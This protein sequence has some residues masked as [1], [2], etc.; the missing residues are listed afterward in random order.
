MIPIKDN[1]ML[2]MNVAEKLITQYGYHWTSI[3]ILQLVMLLAYRPH[4][5][6]I[7]LA[8]KH[9]MATCL[10]VRQHYGTKIKFA[11]YRLCSIKWT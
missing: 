10:D 6:L 8:H 9:G 3:P 11:Y 5:K 2:D 4:E 7:K 1:G